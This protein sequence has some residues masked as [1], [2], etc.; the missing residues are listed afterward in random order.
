MPAYFFFLM[1]GQ[2]FLMLL[3]LFSSSLFRGR[4][5]PRCRSRASVGVQETVNAPPLH[6]EMKS[7]RVTCKSRE[8]VRSPFLFSLSFLRKE[9]RVRTKKNF[10]SQTLSFLSHAPLALASAVARPRRLS[11]HGTDKKRGG[12]VDFHALVSLPVPSS[13]ALGDDPEGLGRQRRG[14]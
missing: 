13:A 6:G 12:V 5:S 1:D 11:R 14:S 4:S 7:R 9:K 3:L 10:L 8:R 2:V